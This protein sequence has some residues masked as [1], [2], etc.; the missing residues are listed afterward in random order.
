MTE[1]GIWFTDECGRTWRRIHKQRGLTDVR[2]VSRERG[3]AIG[4]NKTVIETRDGGKRGAGKSSGGTRHRTR[5]RTTFHAMEFAQPETIGIIAGKSGRNRESRSP[6]W[7]DPR[8]DPKRANVPA[9]PSAGNA[10]W[11]SNLD[12]QQSV[13][14]WTYFARSGL[15]KDG[16]GLALVEFDDYFEFPSEMY[17]LKPKSEELRVCSGARTLPSR[18]SSS[19]DKAYAAGFEP[20]GTIFRSPVPGKVRITRSGNL[21][22]WIE[23][24][25]DYRAVATRVMLA[26]AGD[27]MWAATDTGMIL[28]RT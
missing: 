26:P 4:A 20:S 22:D 25:V 21:T 28:K 14:V 7:L 6:L 5:N 17:R 9:F 18:T 1:S 19:G 15:R 13:H 8:P 24:E 2:F 11:R 12:N 27:Q 10:R 23:C 16:V 3:W